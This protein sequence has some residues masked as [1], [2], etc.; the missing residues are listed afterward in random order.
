MMTEHQDPPDPL[1]DFAVSQ[2]KAQ[3]LYMEAQTA[4]DYFN[5]VPASGSSG[6]LSGVA[7][8]FNL[9]GPK[10]LDIAAGSGT[11]LAAQVTLHNAIT[12]LPDTCFSGNPPCFVVV[13][14]FIYSLFQYKPTVPA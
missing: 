14:I 11:P 9:N 13:V 6:S 5:V 7:F 12:Y 8:Q 2:A 10:F 3:G 4:I 1:H